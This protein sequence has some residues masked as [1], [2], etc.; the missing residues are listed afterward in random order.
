VVLFITM[1]TGGFWVA[2]NLLG[3][4]LVVYLGKGLPFRLPD[5]A[6]SGDLSYGIYIYH[7]P[8]H[9]IIIMQMPQP[10][11]WQTALLSTPIILGFAYVSWHLV[12]RPCLAMKDRPILPPVF[13]L[14]ERLRRSRF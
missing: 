10:E 7:W 4:Y 13:A 12:E 5:M 9:Q 6:R 1:L 11:W 3:A 2:L 8:V 14:G